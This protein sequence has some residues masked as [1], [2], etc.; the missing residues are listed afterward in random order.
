LPEGISS[1]ALI[2]FQQLLEQILERHFDLLSYDGLNP[3][4][5]D[6]IRRVTVLL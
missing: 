2:R 1:F 4:L 6:D 5:D 3:R